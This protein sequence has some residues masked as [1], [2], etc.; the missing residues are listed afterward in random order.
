MLFAYYVSVLSWKKDCLF[1]NI[2]SMNPNC[3]NRVYNWYL[4]KWLDYCNTAQTQRLIQHLKSLCYCW[5]VTLT[6]FAQ[7][8]HVLISPHPLHCWI[9]CGWFSVGARHP[10]EDDVVGSIAHLWCQEAMLCVDFFFYL[11]RLFWSASKSKS[12]LANTEVFHL[13]IMLNKMWIK[14]ILTFLTLIREMKN[15]K[16]YFLSHCSWKQT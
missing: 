5:N 1:P 14:I 16:L 7:V 10:L 2:R 6:R 11:P 9:A 13:K 8:L 12:I 3:Y 4:L 15:T